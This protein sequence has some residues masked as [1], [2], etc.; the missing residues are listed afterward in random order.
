[1]TTKTTKYLAKMSAEYGFKV[2]IN[3]AGKL[4]YKVSVKAAKQPGSR[5]SAGEWVM[6]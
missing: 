4:G 2:S 1:M 3:K 5:R 6:L